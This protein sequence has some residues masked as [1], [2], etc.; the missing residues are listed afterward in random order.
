MTLTLLRSQV[1]E[2]FEENVEAYRQALLAHRFTVGVPAPIPASALVERAVKRVQYPVKQKKADDFVIDYVIEED[3][4]PSFQERKDTIF[5]DVLVAEAAMRKSLLPPPGKMRLQQIKINDVLVAK[6]RA[7]QGKAP[8]PT[9]P[10]DEKLLNDQKEL[11]VRLDELNRDVAQA[12]S[13]VEDL[14]E[15]TIDGWQMPAKLTVEGSAPAEP[16]KGD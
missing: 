1:P 5:N 9:S 13:D 16:V 4:L 8:D 2:K 10:E 15:Q 3:P 11:A 7:A 14:T 6:H 12:L